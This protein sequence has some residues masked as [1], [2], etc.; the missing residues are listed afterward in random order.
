MG[1]ASD[2]D[3]DVDIGHRHLPRRMTDE[4]AT[5]FKCPR[6]PG[7]GA[8]RIPDGVRHALGI[9]PSKPRETEELQALDNM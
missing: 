2:A 1:H 7:P 5:S 8:A 9:E 4:N 3:T 6:R